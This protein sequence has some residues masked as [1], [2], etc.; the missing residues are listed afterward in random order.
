[1]TESI[2]RNERLIGGNCVNIVR[3]NFAIVKNL[4][5]IENMNNI[6]NVKKF[7]KMTKLCWKYERQLEEV[8]GMNK[9]L[10]KMSIVAEN[11]KNVKT[12]VK[13]RRTY[14]QN[15]QSTVGSNF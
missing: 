15:C 14:Q 9:N 12:N 6:G 3:N 11:V 8:K 2:F 1:M 10:W 13:K 5:I 7:W 4:V